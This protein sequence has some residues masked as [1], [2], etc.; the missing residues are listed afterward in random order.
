MKKIFSGIA[1]ILV[2][3]IAAG[4]W[5]LGPIVGFMFLGKPIF[6]VATPTRYANFAFDLVESQGIY[7][8]SADF[9]QTLATAKEELKTAKTIEETHP[10]ILKVLKAGGGK[11]SNLVPPEHNGQASA[12]ETI[13]PTVTDKDRIVTVVVPGIGKSEVT[14]QYAD[15]MAEGLAAKTRNACGVI[16]DLR[17]NNG[18]DMG[19]M[20]AGLSSLLP[21]GPVMSFKSRMGTSDVVISGG[22]IS[23][24]GSPVTVAASTS[25]FTGPVAVL[26]NEKTASSAEATM[27]SFRGL[28]NSRSFGVPTAGYASANIVVDM[29]DGAGIMLT[30]AKDVARTGEE[31]AEEP[32]KPDVV[33]D[34]PEAEATRWLSE[35]CGVK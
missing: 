28:E 10:I 12:E 13:M 8:D 7:A 1:I 24:G 21:D 32:V 30:V 35:E 33:T 22:S 6:V 16:V 20:L 27:L 34:N 2:V 15:I 25:K 23:G 9:E 19:P 14:Q 29:P 5:F 4:T 31:F 26:V 3:A 18:G 17:D 11:H